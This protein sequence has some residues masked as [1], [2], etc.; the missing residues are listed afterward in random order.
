MNTKAAPK[1]Y[2]LLQDSAP[3]API[4]VQVG[5]NERVRLDKLPK[6]SVYLKTSITTEDGS[7]RILRLKLN[8]DSIYQDEQMTK[9]IPANEKFTNAE[10]DA[11]R[12]TN[13]ILITT[14]PVVQKFLDS[15]PENVAFKGMSND[16]LV[17]KFALEDKQAEV[18]ASMTEFRQRLK[19]ANYIDSLSDLREAQNLLIYI[20]GTFYTPPTELAFA[21]RELVN[22]IEENEEALRK[23][24]S[25]EERT[26]TD[27]INIM[28]ARLVQAKVL[29]FDHEPNAISKQINNEWKTIREIS[30]SEY[31]LE[32]RQSHL[33][34]F[35]STPEGLPLLEDLSKDYEALKDLEK[36]TETKPAK[37]EAVLKNA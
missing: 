20:R 28:I 11:V 25:W 34:T 5:K 27:D 9:G 6:A 1:T 31:N 37:K 33:V 32:Q 10:R 15:H 18:K 26:E 4:Y 24:L 14:N 16:G 22:E 3:T 17:P 35:L 8:S 30:S 23:V 7:N 21:Q 12:F 29:A 2:V 36:K 13:G 19:A